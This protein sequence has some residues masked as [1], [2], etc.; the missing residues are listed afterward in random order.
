MFLVGLAGCCYAT[1]NVNGAA[2]MSEFVRPDLRVPL[3]PLP[4][5]AGIARHYL[6]GLRGM[7]FANA[8]RVAIAW[9][10]TGCVLAA[11]S[12]ALPPTW[13]RDVA[14]AS[15]LAGLFAIGRVLALTITERR[16]R[17]FEQDW[18]SARTQALRAHSFDVLR[19]TV[20]DLANRG[21]GTQRT[22][23]LT[24]PG[25]VRELL[26]LRDQEEA[27]SR[28]V[29]LATVEFAYLGDSGVLSVAEAHRDLRELV[30]L[31]AQAGS[32]RASVRFPE[33]RYLPRPTRSGEP[34]QTTNWALTGPVA[35]AVSGQ[36]QAEGAGAPEVP[37]ETSRPDPAR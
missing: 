12:I 15:A 34:A 36:S 14:A 4:G 33:A 27:R 10:V 17:A 25:A 32:G 8:R 1:G 3:V 6:L 11:L 18:I 7:N 19:F 2:C 28:P 30:F 31:P 21:Q 13:Q 23:D 24:S 20:T 9:A 29:L 22:Y 26:G 16:Q 37:A 35:L 5:S